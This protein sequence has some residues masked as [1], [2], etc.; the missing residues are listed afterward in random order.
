MSA[1]IHDVVLKPKA[2]KKR[3]KGNKALRSLRRAMAR[4]KLEQMRDEELL[5]EQIYD[6]FE[7]AHEPE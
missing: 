2:K 5:Q 1:V 7:D 3:N 6:V 4:R